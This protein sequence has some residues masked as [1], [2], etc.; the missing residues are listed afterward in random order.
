MWSFLKTYKEKKK[1]PAS[2]NYLLF[3]SIIL[4]LCVTYEEVLFWNL[5]KR[6]KY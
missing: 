5:G 6:Y 2:A 3:F 4:E 1:V